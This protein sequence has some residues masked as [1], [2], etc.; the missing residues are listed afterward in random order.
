MVNIMQFHWSLDFHMKFFD[1]G[2]FLLPGYK[3]QAPY[4]EGGNCAGPLNA[5]ATGAMI[6]Y[7]LI[8][9]YRIGATTATGMNLLNVKLVIQYF[10][11]TIF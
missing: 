5:P 4:K 9:F 7:Y 11:R 6:S 2:E 8:G 1:S 3:I 10:Y